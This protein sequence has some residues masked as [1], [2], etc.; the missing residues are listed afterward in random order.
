LLCKD[1]WYLCLQSDCLIFKND[2][3]I[4]NCGKSKPQRPLVRFHYEPNWYAGNIDNPFLTGKLLHMM[5]RNCS[6]DSDDA[7]ISNKMR[8]FSKLCQ[9]FHVEKR[10]KHGLRIYCRM[11]PFLLFCQSAYW[12]SK[13]R[14]VDHL[15]NWWWLWKH[16]QMRSAQKLPSFL[17]NLF[18][19]WWLHSEYWLADWTM[20]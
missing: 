7:K 10:H 5:I 6:L 17:R 2:S 3:G 14:P 9:Y 19:L 13:H 18:S 11:P 8:Q 4:G 1:I 16:F 20:A 12:P 15:Y